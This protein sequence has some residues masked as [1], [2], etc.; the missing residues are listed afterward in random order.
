MHTAIDLFLPAG[1]PVLAPLPGRIHSFRNNLMRLD[2]GPTIVLEHAPENGPTF[3]TLYGHLSED[4]LVPLEVGQPVERGQEI[5][6]LGDF[7]SNGDWPPHLHFQV[8]T[9]LLDREGEFPGVALPSQER[10]WRSLSPDPGLMLALPPGSNLKRSE[11][12]PFGTTTSFSLG[13]PFAAQ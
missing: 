11:S 1:S 10:V 4:S 7:P 13:N 5:A 2:Y 9:D 12:I 3:Y 8:I 6:R